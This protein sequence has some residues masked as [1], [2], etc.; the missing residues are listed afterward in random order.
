MDKHALCVSLLGGQFK[1]MALRRGAVV[2]PWEASGPVDDLVGVTGVLAEAVLGT[3][4]EGKTV[5]MVLAHAR[6]LDQVV[7]VPP[8]KHRMLERLLQRRAEGMRTFSGEAAWSRQA[9]LPTRKGQAWLL[10]VCPRVLLDQLARG[11][12]QA[13]LQLVRVLPATAVLAAQLK[14]LPIAKDEVALLVAETG[15]TTTIVIG[16]NDGRVCLA[17]TLQFNW[18]TQPERVQV[19]LTRSIGFAEQQSG[20]TVRSVWLFGKDAEGQVPVLGELLKLPVQLSPVVWTPHYWA[21]QAG[22]LPEREDG[23]L[24]SMETRQA[25]QRRRL[26]TATG[27]LLFLLLASAIGAAAVLE[28]IRGNELV[29]IESLKGQIRELEVQRSDFRQKFAELERMEQTIRVVQE[30]RVSPL[31]GW[32]LAYLG[33]VVPEDLLVTALEVTRTNDLWMIRL[34]GVGQLGPANNGASAP[35]L[36]QVV[37]GLAGTLATGP[38]RLEV[39]RALPEPKAEP[40]PTTRRSATTTAQ[41]AQPA[42][43]ATLSAAAGRGSSAAAGARAVEVGFNQFLIEGVIP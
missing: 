12:E 38:L 8:V 1:A 5:T 4:A 3:R 24:V 17:R 32:F 36:S 11:C 35:E 20:L 2:N 39:T 29:E 27:V 14:H 37:A 33:Q 43:R 15:P 6:V 23:N 42:G 22:R 40:A 31:P 34:A 16:R 18:S 41:P 28:F 25:P 30:E 10:H 26:L 13:G 21:E 9:A 7:E 19:D